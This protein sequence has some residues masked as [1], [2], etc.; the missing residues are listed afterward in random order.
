MPLRS[1]KTKKR[2][3]ATV[4]VVESVRRKVSRARQD[5][6][7]TVRRDEETCDY[8]MLDEQ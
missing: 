7:R 5:V 8:K 4:V 2:P 3:G 6:E 1:T